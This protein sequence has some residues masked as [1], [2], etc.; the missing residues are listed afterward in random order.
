MAVGIID[1]RVVDDDVAIVVCD[2]CIELR[3][4]VYASVCDGCIGSVQF[5]VLHTLCDTAQGECELYVRV[6]FSI[7]G[8]IVHQRGDAEIK[9]VIIAKS[10]RD[11][12]ER[13]DCDDIHGILNSAPQG[14]KTAIGFSIPVAHLRAV[15]IGVGGVILRCGECQTGAVQGRRIGGQNFEGGTRLTVGVCAAVQGSA[16][17]LLAAPA[18]HRKNFTGVLILHSERNLR[19]RRDVD[20]F[21]GDRIPGFHHCVLILL[22]HGL[23]VFFACEL[24]RAAEVIFLHPGKHHVGAVVCHGA[25]GIADRQLVIKEVRGIRR[26]VGFIR[27]V[28]VTNLLDLCILRGVNIQTAGVEQ[29]VCL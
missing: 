26:V 13:L 4:D 14:G 28:V 25:G 12:L 3:L 8:R 20:R 21:A 10:R 11:L 7:D 27:A 18:D 17:R 15:R 24:Q 23:R 6:H 22:R 5:I 19:L 16:R 9:A 2:L 29:R 1:L